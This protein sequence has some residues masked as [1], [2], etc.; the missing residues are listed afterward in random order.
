MH[1]LRLFFT[2]LMFQAIYLDRCFSTQKADFEE[3]FE[4]PSGPIERAYMTTVYKRLGELEQ[5]GIVDV[6]A[7]IRIKD[8]FNRIRRQVLRLQA[9][10]QTVESVPEELD[11]AILRFAGCAKSST[12]FFK[13]GNEEV[14][15]A[16]KVTFSVECYDPFIKEYT[17]IAKKYAKLK[18]HF[19]PHQEIQERHSMGEKIG[20]VES[21]YMS[22]A[23]TRI[24]DLQREH[25]LDVRADLRLRDNLDRGRNQVI[26]LKKGINHSHVKFNR[27]ADF[28]RCIVNVVE[29]ERQQFINYDKIS[30]CIKRYQSVFADILKK[31]QEFQD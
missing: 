27:Q 7:D 24:K 26:D 14:V 21:T 2:F 20:W 5:E 8:N 17:D 18:T 6:R 9:E 10:M 13:I 16:S 4:E 3:S 11:N 30:P 23:V 19:I 25:L 1:L 29:D 12:N 31:E 28:H 15:I 22:S